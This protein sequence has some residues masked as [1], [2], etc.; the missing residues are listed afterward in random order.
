[1]KIYNKWPFVTPWQ[2]LFVDHDSGPVPVRLFPGSAGVQ[3]SPITP[4]CE[5]SLYPNCN[6]KQSGKLANQRIHV[7][8]EIIVRSRA[9]PERDVENYCSVIYAVPHSGY[10]PKS[11]CNVLGIVCI[12]SQCYTLWCIVSSLPS[13]DNL[14]QDLNNYINIKYVSIHILKSTVVWLWRWRY[15]IWVIDCITHGTVDIITYLCPSLGWYL[16][17]KG[18]MVLFAT[19][20]LICKLAIFNA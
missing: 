6:L 13:S 4:S 14:N 15:R 1:M 12:V 5:L 16:S 19:W 17:I 9:S 2:S 3:I 10:N 11:A 18:T 7:V 8:I 20:Y